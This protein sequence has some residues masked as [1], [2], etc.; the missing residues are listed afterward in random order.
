MLL[1]AKRPL[2]LVE[3][4]VARC[5]AL[6]EVVRFAELTGA[7]GLPELDVGRELPGRPSA[8]SGRP[9]PARPPTKEVLKKIDLIVAAGCSLFAEGFFNPVKPTLEASR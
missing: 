6:D 9:R 1:A 4:G 5:D 2:L 3:S 7:A 8:V